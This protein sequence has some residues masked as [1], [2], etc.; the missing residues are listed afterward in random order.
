MGEINGGVINALKRSLLFPFF[1]Q[2]TVFIALWGLSLSL[3]EDED[4]CFLLVCVYLLLYQNFCIQRKRL[5]LLLS[6]SLFRFLKSFLLSGKTTENLKKVFT[7]P[8]SKALKETIT[9]FLISISVLGGSR[10]GENDEKS[11]IWDRFVCDSSIHVSVISM[12]VSD[13]FFFNNL[14]VLREKCYDLS[15]ILIWWV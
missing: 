9:Q 13:S 12:W 14:G 8:K 5:S 4:S 10:K 1:P 6:S 3:C 7:C 15:V 2:Q 11:R